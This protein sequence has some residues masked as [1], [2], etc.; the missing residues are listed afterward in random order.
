MTCKNV[1]VVNSRSAKCFR[2]VLISVDSYRSI[3]TEATADE[4]KVVKKF[5]GHILEK[6][7]EH[8]IILPNMI[9]ASILLQNPTGIR[10]GKLISFLGVLLLFAHRLIVFDIFK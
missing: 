8:L 7:Q 10:L 9:V 4:M 1:Q 2:L 3:R 5:A 6:I